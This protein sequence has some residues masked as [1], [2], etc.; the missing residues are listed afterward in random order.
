MFM[1]PRWERPTTCSIRTDIKEL[2]TSER[3]FRPVMP[4][5]LPSSRALLTVAVAV[6]T[7]LSGCSGLSGSDMSADEIGDRIEQKHENIDSYEAT[8]ERQVDSPDRDLSTKSKI[9]AKPQAGLM[10]TEALAPANQRGNV[11]VSNETTTWM[12]NA[13]ANTARQMDSLGV[14]GMQQP[15]YGKLVDHFTENYDISVEGITTVAD[16]SVYV[17]DLTPKENASQFA[18]NTTLWVDKDRWFPVKTKMRYSYDNETTTVTTTYRNLSFNTGVD[19]STFDFEPP[20]NATIETV[21]TP[22]TQQYDT[23]SAAAE[24]ASVAVPDPAVP[25]EYTLEQAIVSEYDDTVSVRLQYSNGSSHLT[26]A[27]QVG[28][29]SKSTRGNETVQVGN[30]TGSYQQIGDHR[31]LNWNC[32]DSSYTATGEL[33]KDELLSTAESIDC[34]GPDN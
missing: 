17:L 29:Q 8:I 28:Q 14:T 30:S 3:G 32:A 9:V 33:S 6:L 10:R 27:K 22:S 20:A 5:N 21:S 4:L 1:E 13:S 11:M 24:N 12:Y 19:N 18:G 23:R 25:D 26:V 15:N 16:R 31:I 34:S 2:K 7:V